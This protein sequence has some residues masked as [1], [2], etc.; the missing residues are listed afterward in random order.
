[1][2]PRQLASAHGANAW[3]MSHLSGLPEVLPGTEFSGGE[4]PSATNPF[5]RSLGFTIEPKGQSLALAVAQLPA[6][7]RLTNT[8]SSADRR[9]TASAPWS[10]EASPRLETSIRGG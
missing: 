4:S 1:M 3:S 9:P 2:K 8:L 10:T 5:L 6:R 7:I